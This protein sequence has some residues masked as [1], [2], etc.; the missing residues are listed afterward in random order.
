M[1]QNDLRRWM[2]VAQQMVLCESPQ[3]IQEAGGPFWE[4][5]RIFFTERGFRQIGYGSYGRVY[6]KP[7]ANYVI[8]IFTADPCYSRFLSLIAANKNKH[9]PVLLAEP[10]PLGDDTFMVKMERLLPASPANVQ[11]VQHV[12]E[13]FVQYS[14]LPA[15]LSRERVNAAL[16]PFAAYPD[17]IRAVKLLYDGLYSKGCFFDLAARNLMQRQDG[18]VVILDPVAVT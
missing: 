1:M 14:D 2:T 7:S 12:A 11:L 9:F 16:K 13:V 15:S 10:R 18:T 6:G 4:K 5:L 3:T 17:L 8:K